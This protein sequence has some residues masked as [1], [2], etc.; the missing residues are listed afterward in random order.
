MFSRLLILTA[1]LLLSLPSASQAQKSFQEISEETNYKLVKL[2]GSGGFR[3]VVA[4][5]TGIVISEDGYILT[6]ASQM[7]N[8]SELRVHMADGRKHIARCWS[9][10]PRST[11]PC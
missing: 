10:S 7:L 4:Y 1:C 6:V 11:W 5:G 8:T 3:G 2:F 9:R